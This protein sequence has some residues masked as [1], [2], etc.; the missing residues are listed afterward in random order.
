LSAVIRERGLRWAAAIGLAAVAACGPAGGPQAT[1]GA[2]G[3]HEFQG[4]W[5]ASG[6][7]RVISLGE[8]RS[9]SVVGLNGSLMLA[10]PSRPGV[11]FR[12]EAIAMSDSASG[13]VGRA[14]WTN[15]K[16]EQAFSELRGEGTAAKNRIEGK[17]VGGTGRYAGA[18]GT[19]EFS[20]QYVL[21]TEDGTVQGRATDLKGRIRIDEAAK[22]HAS[23][24]LQP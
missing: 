6:S 7:R 14:V 23:G 12:A 1:P 24:K 9:A 8:A 18:A 15:E 22:S 11:G 16:G 19:Y 21:E 17:F 20:W 4:S 2:E 13:L 3:W 5:T 10:G